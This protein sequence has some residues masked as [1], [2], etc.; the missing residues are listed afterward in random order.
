M[1]SE[2]NVW[3]VHNIMIFLWKIIPKLLIVKISNKIDYPSYGSGLSN[4]FE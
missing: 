1:Y 4:N 3:P 2:Y